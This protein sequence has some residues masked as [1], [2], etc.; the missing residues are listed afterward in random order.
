M[1]RSDPSSIWSHSWS[2][3]E[4]TLT[5]SIAPIGR[6]GAFGP[7]LGGACFT[8]L[9]AAASAGALIS[10]SHDKGAFLWIGLLIVSACCFVPTLRNALRI[11]FCSTGLRWT[12]TSCTLTDR[13]LGWTKTREIALTPNTQLLA[14]PVSTT[15]RTNTSEKRLKGIALY[16]NPEVHWMAR[17]LEGD[18]AES[19]RRVILQRFPQLTPRPPS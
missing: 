17:Q 18:D 10:N 15:E 14:G 16:L 9:L 3:A 7:L 4:K 12:G 8:L 6:R 1:S 13:T 19:L 2:E 5:I 11:G